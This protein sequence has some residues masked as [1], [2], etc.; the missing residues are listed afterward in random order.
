MSLY[1][2]FFLI[3]KIKKN[4]QYFGLLFDAYFHQIFN[5]TLRRTTDVHI[6]KDITSN[7]FFKALH[8]I[9][10][11]KW[12]N[13]SISSWLYRIASNEIATYYRNKSSA[14]KHYALLCKEMKLTDSEQKNVEDE[15]L[16]AEATLSR[17]RQYQEM[18]AILSELPIPYQEVI[19]LKYFEHKKIREIA[20]IMGK[21]QNSVKSLLYRG[22]DLLKGKML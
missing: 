6:S 3:Q 2:D 11:F 9:G 1:N 21:N 12:K 5:Y 8:S 22:L 17:H 18:R 16:E 13:I 7:V 4:P 10:Q 20:E 15:M 19:T 14:H